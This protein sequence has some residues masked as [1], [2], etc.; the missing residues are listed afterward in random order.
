MTLKKALEILELNV[1]VSGSRMPPDTLA[2]LKLGIEGIKA[3]SQQRLDPYP[4]PM[5]LLKGETPDEDTS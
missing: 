4:D 3:I 1:R 2:A 5:S